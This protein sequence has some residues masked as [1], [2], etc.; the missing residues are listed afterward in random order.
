MLDAYAISRLRP[1]AHPALRHSIRKRD[2]L[3][4]CLPGMPDVYN[5][6]LLRLLRDAVAAR[7]RAEDPPARAPPPKDDEPAA[8]TAAASRLAGQLPSEPD[9]D[10]LP[11]A[12]VAR[13]NLPYGGRPFVQPAA[14]LATSDLPHPARGET[15][16][17]SGAA[18]S[19]FTHSPPALVECPIPTASA[20]YGRHDASVVL[21][22]DR[23]VGVCTDGDDAAVLRAE[24]SAIE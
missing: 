2:C 9:A 10:S 7:S 17:P 24:G 3:H 5:G 1:D 19:I 18:L 16:P 22:P 8:A 12:M 14:L 20:I 4:Y 11:G 21:V 23:L 13:W 6:R 15:G